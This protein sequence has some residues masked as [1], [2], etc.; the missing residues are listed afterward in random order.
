M[1]PTEKKKVMSVIDEFGGCFP[2]E[3]VNKLKSECNIAVKDMQNIRVCYETAKKHPGHLDKGADD[4][5]AA[6]SS[7]TPEVEAALAG[8]KP[9]SHGL[10]NFELKPTD[11]TGGELF[12]Q[13]T[14]YA[15]RHS[16]EGTTLA[17]AQYLDVEMTSDQR[18]LLNPTLHDL[19]LRAIMRD[20]GGNG[21][22]RKL[23][24][25]KL[26]NVGDIKAHC[27]IQN[28]P[29]RIRQ[30]S[31]ARELSASITEIARKEHESA[32]AKKVK[33]SGDLLA[34]APAAAAKLKFKQ[35]N[36]NKLKKVEIV[37]VALKY[38]AVELKLSQPKPDLVTALEKAIADKPTALGD[39]APLSG[40]KDESSA[41]GG[42]RGR[43]GGRGGVRGPGRGGGRA[44]GKQRA[45]AQE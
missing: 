27:G 39:V 30:L 24:R 5:S 14:T 10:I 18:M 20:S 28:N 3:C 22:L 38:F 11:M 16:S 2:I 44:K 13:M 23:A 17:P 34:E 31:A 1:E 42:N 37:A 8:Q 4:D 36:A 41:G 43:S 40:N 29:E 45:R 19:T 21:A 7:V 33:A 32:T 15:R 26:D 9:V 6:S 12:D 25:R 35:G